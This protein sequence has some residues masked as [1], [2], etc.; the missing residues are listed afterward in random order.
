MEKRGTPE[1]LGCAADCPVPRP[2]EHHQAF[3][4]LQNISVPTF[5]LG[6]ATF[7][8]RWGFPTAPQ[9]CAM[10]TEHRAFF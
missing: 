10:L 6:A 9:D 5:S 1:N 7:P 3:C 8:W 4:T 2:A